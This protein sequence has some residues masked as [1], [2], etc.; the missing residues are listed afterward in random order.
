MK[1]YKYSIAFY[2]NGMPFDGSTLETKDLG[3]SETIGLQMAR[4]LKQQGHEVIVFSNCERE[5]DYNGVQYLNVSRFPEWA[6]YTPHDITIVQRDPQAFSFRINSKLHILWS[7]DLALN[8]FTPLVRGTLW[9][10]DQV[11]VLSE[12]MKDQYKEVY[13]LPDEAF[14]VTRNGID[15]YLLPAPRPLEQRDRNKVI[16]T[17]RPERGMDIVLEKTFPRLL[18]KLPNLKLYLAGYDNRV[19]HLAGLYNKIDNLIAGLGDKVVHLGALR[20]EDLYEHYRTSML[21]LYPSDFEEISC[22]TA[23]ECMAVGLPM[24]G[25]FRAALP[26]T[27]GNQAGKLIWEDDARGSEYQGRFITESLELLT[28]EDKWKENSAAGYERSKLFGLESLGQEW[29]KLFDEYFENATKDKVRLAYHFTRR[30]DIIA[31][32]ASLEKTNDIRKGRL[33]KRLRNQWPFVYDYKYIENEEIAAKKYLGEVGDTL[34]PPNPPRWP[35][36]KR[37]LEGHPKVKNILD[38]GCAQGEYIGAILDL[39]EKYHVDGFDISPSM[40]NSSLKVLKDKYSKDR[41]TVRVADILTEKYP[42]PCYDLVLLMEVLEHTP[43]PWKLADAAEKWLKPGGIILVTT[44][45]GTWEM[46]TYRKDSKREHIWE[47]ENW[48][49]KGMFGHKPNF[50][51]MII[52][53]SISDLD[54]V[55]LGWYFYTW[56]EG[57]EPAKPID[58]DRKLY[59]QNPRQTI[60]VCMIVKNGE[61]MLRRCLKSVDWIADE[62]IVADDNSTD[63]TREILKGYADMVID[64]LSPVEVGFD[65]ARNNSIKSAQMD[66]ILWIDADE[67]LLRTNHIDKYLRENIFNGYAIRQHHF[68]TNP[69]NAFPPDLP[70]RLFRN[71]KSIKFFGV[72]HEHPEIGLNKSVGDVTLLGDVEIAHDGYFTEEGRIKR[73]HR[74]FHLM[75]RDREKYPDRV[76]GKFLMVRDWAHLARYKLQANR[77]QMTEEIAGICHNAINLY[78]KEFLGNGCNIRWMIDGLP[79]YS[80]AVGFLGLGIKAKIAMDIKPDNPDPSNNFLEARFLN[81]DDIKAF[82]NALIND[83]S[84]PWMGKYV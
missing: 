35:A 62:I 48:D 19:Q 59:V 82:T 47:L 27:L 4:T 32:K 44:P 72:V 16:Y 76:L 34:R 70:V 55:A 64:G 58:M 3:G 73:F 63:S 14:K 80:E 69:P 20:K 46:F 22:I 43:E 21:Y 42:H 81:P 8:R 28:N 53:G 1:H 83:M 56:Q 5:G 75:I 74:N 10:V 61:D 71:N 65:E 37:W 52:P 40:V 29:S 57:G 23:M 49:I 2:I 78:R 45:M 31:A 39:D 30:S 77:G 36:V 26:E 6:I 60:S 12:F 41:Y 25:S 50:Q 24:V 67:E 84:N 33:S 66:W 13:K 15:R 54:G 7:H 17:A 9:N 51:K 18:E 79:Y 38:I 11:W 68:S